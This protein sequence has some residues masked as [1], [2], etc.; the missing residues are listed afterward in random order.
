MKKFKSIEEEIIHWC[1]RY[2]FH[3]NNHYENGRFKTKI[4]GL[5]GKLLGCQ[6]SKDYLCLNYQCSYGTSNCVNQ[7]HYPKSWAEKIKNAGT[8]I[9][10]PS[11]V[12]M[13]LVDSKKPVRYV[14][15]GKETTKL[16]KLK[17]K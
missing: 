14:Y 3:K 9:E 10:K 1:K 5:T 12:I 15:D 2:Y 17:L 7:K 8:G 16:R 6:I 4:L 13:S 11:S